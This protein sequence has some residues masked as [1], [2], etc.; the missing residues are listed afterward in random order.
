MRSILGTEGR[1][2]ES[3]NESHGR[4]TAGGQRRRVVPIGR[5]RRNKTLNPTQR[6][7]ARSLARCLLAAL[8]ATFCPEVLALKLESRNFR[9]PTNPAS[10]FSVLEQVRF[11]AIW[12]TDNWLGS[13]LNQMQG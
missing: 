7:L 4:A 13:S 3:G 9:Q 5:K 11:F 6:Q 1:K 12:P 8:S 10:G 2:K